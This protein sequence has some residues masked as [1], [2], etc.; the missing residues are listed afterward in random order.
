MLKNEM[1]IQDTSISPSDYQASPDDD[2]TMATV[3]VG[4]FIMSD[5]H[6]SNSL[7]I[8]YN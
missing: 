7:D 6:Y 1:F 2:L 5:I 3:V 8:S 4:A